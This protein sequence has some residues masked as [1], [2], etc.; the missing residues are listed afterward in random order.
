MKEYLVVW[1]STVAGDMGTATKVK[2]C[3]QDEVEELTYA[4][5]SLDG[6]KSLSMEEYVIDPDNFH[7]LTEYQ[8][9]ILHPYF[10]KDGAGYGDLDDVLV[11]PIQ[12]KWSYKCQK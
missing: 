4:L 10:A 8:K 12:S 6:T 3:T 5:S 2:E 11:Y 7:G 9:D 1:T